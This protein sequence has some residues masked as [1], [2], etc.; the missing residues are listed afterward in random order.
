MSLI[1]KHVAVLQAWACLDLVPVTTVVR[2]KIDILFVSQWPPKYSGP[3]RCM[4]VSDG[5]ESSSWSL[6]A[7][8]LVVITL[9]LTANLYLVYN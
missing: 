1:R 5:S 8:S 4:C 9:Q 3:S 6:E 2:C 7:A